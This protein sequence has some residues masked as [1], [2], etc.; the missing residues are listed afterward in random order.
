MIIRWG[1]FILSQHYIGGYF[2]SKENILRKINKNKLI[3][4]T[5]CLEKPWMTQKLKKEVEK[6]EKPKT[7]YMWSKK[8]RKAHLF[9]LL[10]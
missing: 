7:C 2:L 4:K 5:K 10:Y 8:E 6:L 3:K 1:G 9:R